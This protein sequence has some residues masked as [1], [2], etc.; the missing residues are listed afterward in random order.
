MAGPISRVRSAELRTVIATRP[1]PAAGAIGH[2]GST[3]AETGPVTNDD[4]ALLTVDLDNG[5]VGQIT[6]SRIA[7]G[8]PNSLGVEVFGTNGHARFDSI[9]AG[10]FQVYVAD[11]K[12][13]PSLVGAHN[14]VTGPAHPYFTDVAAMPGGGVGTGYAEAFTAEVQEFLR[15][16]R[17]HEPMDTDF[18]TALSM[19]KVVGAALQSSALQQPVDIR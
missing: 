9:R 2:G 7:H 1:K 5:A 8:V 17:D 3:S 14:I 18:E 10:E 15:S 19:M 12:L 4:I 13:S 11:E 6:L 16:V